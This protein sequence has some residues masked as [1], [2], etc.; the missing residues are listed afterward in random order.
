MTL[1]EEL[2][3]AYY[4][5]MEGFDAIQRFECLTLAIQDEVIDRAEKELAKVQ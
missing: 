5:A 4:E 2:E 3:R 1:L